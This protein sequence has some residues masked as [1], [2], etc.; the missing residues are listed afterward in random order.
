M[1]ASWNARAVGLNLPAAETIELAA[2]AGFGGVDLLVR[3]LDEAGEDPAA[4]RARMDELGLQGG[5]WPLPVMWKGQADRFLEDLRQLP[6]YARIARSLGLKCTG[7]WVLPE[8][9]RDNAPDRPI[10]ERIAQTVAFHVERLGRIARI[11]N[12]HGGRLG[13]EIMGPTTARRGIAP[14]FVG[15]YRELDEQLG[16]LR[17]RHENVGFLVDAFHLFA[18]G[19]GYE[20]GFAWGVERV[21]WV[22][23]ADPVH[24]DRASLLDTERS[25]P[26]KTELGE[27]RTLLQTLE[28][29]GYRG[30]VTVE[31][32]ASCSELQGLPSEDVATRVAASLA[33][34]WPPA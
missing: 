20:A 15:R 23:V 7:T 5:A 29:R 31:P 33:S 12:D 16:E 1:F 11:L 21:L 2:R 34:V 28:D 27:A 22:H 3:D 4:L 18:A 9:I 14:A 8:L 13:L 25:L 19:E 26:G 32:L 30:P 6:R 17:D 10:G 24:T